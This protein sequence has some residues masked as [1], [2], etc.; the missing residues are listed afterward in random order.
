MVAGARAMMRYRRT[1]RDGA[2]PSNSSGSGNNNP[3]SPSHHAPK[4][5]FQDRL[6]S[7]QQ[8]PI[9]IQAPPVRKVD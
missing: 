4:I 5:I 9:T 8:A 6:R 7:Q 2:I 3:P 1:S